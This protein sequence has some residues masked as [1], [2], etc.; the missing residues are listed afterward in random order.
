[1][2]LAEID[3]LL[4]D[5]VAK[6]VP[7]MLREQYHL[8][9]VKGG[10]R[11]PHLPEQSHFAHIVNGVLA[12]AGLVKFLVARGVVIPGGM[13]CDT[14]RKALGL[15]TVHES[16]KREGVELLGG[17]EYSI[18]LSQL[19]Q[20]YSRLG[21]EEFVELDN[22]LMRSANVHKRS[23]KHG[24]LLLSEDHGASHLWLLVRLADALASVTT[25]QE[26][27][28]SLRSY[29]CDLSPAFVPRTPPGQYAL[30]YH[31]L[32]DVRGVL[33]NTI[34]EAVAGHLCQE[35][36]FWPLL[37]FA[38]GT[39]YVGPAGAEVESERLVRA[40]AQTVC[41]VLVQHGGQGADAI[42]GALR[43]TYYD[44]ET[45]AYSFAS[46]PALLEVVRDDCLAPQKPS[47]KVIDD[48]LSGLLEK[49]GLP[50]GWTRET[51][52]DRLGVISAS[53]ATLREHWVRA[54][55]YLLYVD[56]LVR[57]LCPGENALEWL[58]RSLGM[59]P[60]Y[61]SGLREVGELWARGGP[62]KYVLPIAYHF[63]TGPE[64]A[65]RAAD[66]LPP[67]EVLER[68]HARVLVEMEKLDTHSGRQAA[69]AQLGL[70][71]DLEDYLAERLYVSFAPRGDPG[72]D[73]LP[74]YATVKG[75]GHTRRICSIC[76]RSSQYVVELR[77]GIL[78]DFGRVFSNRVLPAREAPQGN[79]LWCPVCQL[80]FILRK[81]TGMG[82]PARAHY[83]KSRRIYLYVLPTFSFTREHLRIYEPLL[84][85]FHR[86]SSLPVRDY[87]KD[88]GL[89]REW[90][91]RRALDSEWVERL[92]EI[93]EREASKIAG[94]G[95]ADFVGERTSLVATRA[96]PHYY[97]LM[98]EKAASEGEKDDGRIATRTEAWAKG[99]FAAAVI[100]AL[101]NCRVYVTERPYLPV[102]DAAELPGT[103]TLD[104]PPAGLAGV[105]VGRGDSVSLSGR[106]T[107]GGSGLPRLL[108]VSCAL[109]LVTCEVHSPGRE[110]KDK[111]VS[112]RLATMNSS[113]LA[114]ATFYKE[115]ARL[116]GG[117][118]PEPLLATACRIIL[119][120]QAEAQGGELMDLV[121]AIGE[122]CL[123]IALPRGGAGRGK[124]RRYE[125]IFREA[126]S[127]LRQAWSALPEMR[128]GAILGR[129]A[130]PETIVQLKRLAA[131]TLLKSL[132][133]RRQSRRG[134]VWIHARA[135]DLGRL[136]G[137]L[138]DLV[139]DHLLLDRAA[140]SFARFLR[141][142]NT[143]ADGIYYY[144]D[145]N[146]SRLWDEHKQQKAA[147]AAANPTGA[148]GAQ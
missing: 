63:L 48:D 126:V 72:E 89:P 29:L 114:G 112:S 122:K 135:R 3:E 131:G 95:G 45:Y 55:R 16:H 140:G 133:R 134:E 1:M 82:L 109:W 17:S 120:A 98:W 136:A 68:L 44:F 12:L 127:A 4:D 106:E 123:E 14:L 47:G 6:V 142:E 64:F 121:T 52:E 124:P 19:R 42:R 21:L 91:G 147:H 85:P 73:A 78:D 18:P 96:L 146:L 105:L 119:E 11:F 143:M 58:A 56:K 65:S 7:A 83:G 30:Y 75:R 22:H 125:L 37:Y 90:L 137:E 13:H 115:Y 51:V 76:N 50:E 28:S 107:G 128:E 70:R 23:P 39:L 141:L 74:A 79:R 110:T 139:V 20:E 54:R 35:L 100:S 144:T 31:E 71:E 99:V 5:F 53:S 113:A 138:V 118:S 67:G 117:Q 61:A 104:S 57:A 49:P 84:R 66:T 88:S 59:P 32:R 92:G 2:E 25:P 97:L 129:A 41:E 132:E 27:V 36:G 24:D 40:V 87:G 86:V 80:E 33:T 81:L 116:N 8:V 60:V 69:V 38:T 93:L 43:Q 130:S 145:Q 94:W 46:V 108:D 9:L 15:Y 148:G 101:T 103:I 77:T 34:H 111:H 26:A 10:P 62:G 102:G